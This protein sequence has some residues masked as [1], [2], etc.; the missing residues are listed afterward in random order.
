MRRRRN[1][2]DEEIR[3]VWRSLVESGGE[4]IELVQRYLTAL[5]R[6]DE[7][8]VDESVRRMREQETATRLVKQDYFDSIESTAEELIDAIREGEVTDRNRLLDRVDEEAS[9][10]RWARSVPAARFAL[11][12]S[13]NWNYALESDVLDLH[14][15]A[16]RGAI[17]WEAMAG[18]AFNRDLLDA[19]IR[20]GIDLSDDSEWPTPE[21]LERQRREDEDEDVDG[22]DTE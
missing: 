19:P 5:R 7:S 10:S 3:R 9:S 4:D 18:W 14:R 13:E 21:N 12:A 1:S 8:P 17:P 2:G 22:E 16:E 20:H 11:W 6:R 15:I